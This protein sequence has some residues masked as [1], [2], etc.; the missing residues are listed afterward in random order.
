MCA[1][2]VRHGC[3]QQCGEQEEIPEAEAFRLQT[4]AEIGSSTMWAL[5]GRQFP[6]VCEATVRPCADKCR[7]FGQSIAAGMGPWGWGGLLGI[8]QVGGILLGPWWVNEC[9]DSCGCG[10]L[11]KVRLYGQVRE[12]VSVTI[13]GNVV[14]PSTYFVDHGRSELISR[15]TP[16]PACQQLD[17]ASGDGTFIIVYRYGIEPPALGREAAKALGCEVY[18]ALANRACNLP[19]GVTRLVRQGVTIEKAATF[20]TL[21]ATGS[22]GIPLVDMF[23]ASANPT[24]AQRPPAVYSPD[25]P[26]YPREF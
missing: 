9:G 13:D 3:N 8:G 5:S 16:W 15:G 22:T 14:D 24:G 11:S 17:K 10:V 7:C 18:K 2:Y 6:G 1:R 21:F 26:E 4:A 19:A 25:L 20:A 12:I 23:M